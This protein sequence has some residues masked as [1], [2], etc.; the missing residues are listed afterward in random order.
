MSTSRETVRDA[1]VALLTTALTGVAKTVVGSKVESLK[2]LTPLVSVLPTGSTREALSFQGNVAS[3]GL[4]VNVWVLQ[5]DI[6]WT[7]AQAV[8]ALDR[9][10]SI[11]AG[12]YETA[13]G[14]GI[15]ESI[16]YAGPT[17]AGEALVAGIEYYLER[18]PTIVVLAKN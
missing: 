17:E 7:N 16:K 5:K 13:R 11:I 12:V 6:G 4:V 2:G 1:L 14:T 10:E 18:I 3:F 8:D 15:W 9:I